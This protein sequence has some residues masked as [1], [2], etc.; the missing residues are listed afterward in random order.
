MYLLSDKGSKLYINLTENVFI[1]TQSSRFRKG[2]I[3]ND[4]SYKSDQ[5]QGK[6]VE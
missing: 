6:V 5:R 1:I 4:W 2:K 3:A